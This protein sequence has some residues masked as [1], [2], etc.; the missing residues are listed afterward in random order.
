M[1]SSS[2]KFKD[3]MFDNP[4]VKNDL[5][6]GFNATSGKPLTEK[7]QFLNYKRNCKVINETKKSLS[8]NLY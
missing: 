8:G 7:S 1:N 2:K 4:S 5:V 3:S 6:K